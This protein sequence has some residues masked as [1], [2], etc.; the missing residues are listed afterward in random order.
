MVSDDHTQLTVLTDR[1]HGGTSLADGQAEIM[2]GKFL[3][4]FFKC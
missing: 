2:V 4:Y 1:S 3:Q